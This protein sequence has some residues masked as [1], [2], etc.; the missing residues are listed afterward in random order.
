MFAAPSYYNVPLSIFS[1]GFKDWGH[2][3]F[4]S[5]CRGTVQMMPEKINFSWQRARQMAKTRTRQNK[6][7]PLHFIH[8][9][10][11]QRLFVLNCFAPNGWLSDSYI[12]QFSFI[13]CH[14]FPMTVTT[15]NSP[16]DL[17]WS[18]SFKH[19]SSES[20]TKMGSLVRE[21]HS[22]LS[23]YLGI[24]VEGTVTGLSAVAIPAILKWG[25]QYLSY[26]FSLRGSWNNFC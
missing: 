11:W 4:L 15:W 24:M 18:N 1:L 13:W 23:V 20:T 10:S 26:I 17:L 5:I 2:L 25:T 19:T 7:P 14:P 8:N 3:S 16:Q 22:V 12:L 21:L 6:K 9:S